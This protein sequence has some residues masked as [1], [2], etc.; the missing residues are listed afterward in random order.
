M[1][2]FWMVF[3]IKNEGVLSRFDTYDE[4]ELEAKRRA[5]N[6]GQGDF[7]ILEAVA[8]AKQPVPPIE[9]TKL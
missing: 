2:K 3:G 6:A 8:V 5:H 9:V 7:F 4:A 1:K